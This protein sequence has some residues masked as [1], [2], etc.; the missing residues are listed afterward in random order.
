LEARQVFGVLPEGWE[1]RLL[2]KY[3]PRCGSDCSDAVIYGRQRSRCT[4]CD[5]VHFVNPAPGVTV[6]VVRDHDVLLCRRAPGVGYVGGDG[7]WC[8]P[9]GH[10]EYNEDFITA[11]LRETQEET[12]IEVEIAGLLSVVSNFWERGASTLAVVLLASP[13]G[14]E[15]QP[16]HHET[17]EVGWYHHESLPELAFE[18]DAHIIARYFA[19]RESGA[20]V[21]PAYVR[22]SGRDLAYSPPPAAR[23]S[24]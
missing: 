3:C 18:A 20:R 4:V 2:I 9:G 22:L 5:Y 13:I 19:T 11:G 8:L 21:D 24:L 6:M 23:P 1:E 10:I 17:T 15:M 12:G 14:G 7:K 16:D